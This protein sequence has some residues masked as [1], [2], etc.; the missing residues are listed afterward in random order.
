MTDVIHTY[1]TIKQLSTGIYKEKGSKFIGYAV[2][3]YSE[4]EAKQF[5]EQ[6][7]KEHHQARHVCYAYRLGRKKDKFRANDDG[8]PANS[9]GAPILGQIQSFDLTNVLI[10]VVRYFGGTKLGVGGLIQAY[11][12]AALEAINAGEIVTCELRH[13]FKLIVTFEEYPMLMKQA[14]QLGVEIKKQEITD[15]YELEISLPLDRTDVFQV[16]TSENEKFELT[17]YGIF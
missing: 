11:R 13:H 10:G 7:R 4:E 14:K 12:T 5:L 3:C 2:A 6:W 8:E 9:A 17:D 16:F 15:V 1:R